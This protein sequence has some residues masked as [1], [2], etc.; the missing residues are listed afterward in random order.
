MS[1]IAVMGASL[2]KSGLIGW[3]CFYS[4]PW[5]QKRLPWP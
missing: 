5:R 3:R 4:K 2:E 1:T